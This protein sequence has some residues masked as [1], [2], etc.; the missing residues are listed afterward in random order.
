MSTAWT[1]YVFFPQALQRIGSQLLLSSQGDS[2]AL[3]DQGWLG[4]TFGSDDNGTSWYV[5]AAPATPTSPGPY[6][7]KPC[8]VSATGSGATCFRYPLRPPATGFGDHTQAV[9]PGYTFASGSD[10]RLAMG[11]AVNATVTFPSSP[12]PEAWG[13]LTFMM[14]TDGTVLPLRDGSLLM[15]VYGRYLNTTTYS[16]A[17]LRSSDKGVGRA[18]HWLATVSHGA[19][20]PC[21][22]PSEHDC[23]RLDSGAIYCVWRSE[24]T[25]KPLCSSTSTDEGVTWTAAEPLRG[26]TAVPRSRGSLSPPEPT[27]P[28]GVEPKLVKLSNGKLVL[29]TGR[30]GVFVWAAEDPPTNGWTP[31]NVAVHHNAAYPNASF[32][33]A[34][35]VPTTQE[36]TSYTGLV[37]F[38]GTND[39]LLSYDYLANGWNPA[40]WPN[41]ASA[42][43]TVRITVD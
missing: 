23:A 34:S 21:G 14:V 31:F 8:V 5:I 36:T 33:Y 7:V 43:F 19:P 2:D 22:M 29:S 26:R 15:L 3:H 4:R 10:G 18:W 12:A 39:V 20:S 42:I 35:P 6:L 13:N 28:Y 32:H 24:G 27:V 1:R 40:P 16:I 37:S 9:M 38:P 30:P 11:P 25:G 17:A 41:A